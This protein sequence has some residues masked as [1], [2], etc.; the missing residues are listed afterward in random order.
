MPA[1]NLQAVMKGASGLEICGATWTYALRYDLICV[2][3]RQV[4]LRL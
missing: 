4:R 2:K 1:G 3:S